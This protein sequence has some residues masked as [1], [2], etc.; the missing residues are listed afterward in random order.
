MNFDSTHSLKEFRDTRMYVQYAIGGIAGVGV[1]SAFYLFKA[2]GNGQ[3][4]LL[5]AAAA[6]LVVALIA[7]GF[8]YFRF[9]KPVV[10]RQTAEGIQRVCGEREQTIAYDDL[11]GFRARWTDVIRNGV[12][13]TTMVR[14]ALRSRDAG[15]RVINY[16]S[17]AMYDTV[18]YEQ[19]QEFQNEV[20][21]A[22]ATQMA[23]ELERTGR[24]DWTAKL[25][26]RRDGLE[27]VRKAGAAPE[28]VAFDRVSDWKVDQ[29]LFKLG[30]DG[31][32][33]PVLL[34]QTTEWNFYPGLLLWSHCS[35]QQSGESVP[36]EEVP[37]TLVN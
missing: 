6:A 35:H 14:F 16:D 26:I 17:S 5:I 3:P 21:A 18:K 11:A 9:G 4:Q 24:V 37:L 28:V 25:A 13:Q 23:D 19:L 20:S 34:E 1:V 36:N 33:R 10:L 31:S 30:I 12:Y 7:S 27:I 2:A 29:G 8:V 32:H 15:E 22:V